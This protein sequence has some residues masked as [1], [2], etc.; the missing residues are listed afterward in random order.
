[1]Q[2]GNTRRD[3]NRKFRRDALREYLSERNGLVHILNQ[4]EKLESAQSDDNHANLVAA[5]NMRIRLMQKYLPDIKAVE[6]SNGDD[7]PLMVVIREGLG[8]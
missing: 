5:L 3:E 1:M 2:K 7:G 6:M 8:E 4:I